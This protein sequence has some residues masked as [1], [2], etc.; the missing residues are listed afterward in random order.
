MH[1]HRNIPFV[2]FVWGLILICMFI[3]INHT[4]E[5][6]ETENI[7]ENIKKEI[8]RQIGLLE[9]TCISTDNIKQIFDV[10]KPQLSYLHFVGKP[11]I[12]MIIEVLTD[13]NKDW[14]LRFILAQLLSNMK[15]KKAIAP[16]KKI[17][18]DETDIKSIRVAS[19]IALSKLK[20]DEVIDPLLKI[21]K[22][23]DRELQLAA[24]YGLGELRR[25]KVINELKKWVVNEK[26]GQ[27]KK[28][29]EIAIEKL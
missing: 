22:G 24:I 23:N 20:F 1:K 29:L 25:E 9:K 12:P 18:N 4:F 8:W 10:A 13:K 11:G 16:L 28:E 3:W 17:L 5:R 14:K 7:S 6:K 27:I 26:D 19:A 2:I 15:T 21:A